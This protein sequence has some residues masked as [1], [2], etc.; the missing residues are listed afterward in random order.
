MQSKEFHY[1]KSIE[2]HSQACVGMGNVYKTSILWLKCFKVL[3]R[4]ELYI[5]K[6]ICF[7]MVGWRKYCFKWCS[8]L[9]MPSDPHKNMHG[10]P[11]WEVYHHYIDQKTIVIYITIY[12]WCEKIKMVLALPLV[13]TRENII[14]D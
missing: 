1:K 8:V 4:V 9:L 14:W 7:Y 6:L 10:P 13:G 3:K 5:Q 12:I 11:R 2:K